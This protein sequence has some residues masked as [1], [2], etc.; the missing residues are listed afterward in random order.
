MVLQTAGTNIRH[1]QT[2]T[3]N[4]MPM[5]D[6]ASDKILGCEPGTIIW[7]HERA[8]QI[9]YHTNVSTQNNTFKWWMLLLCLASLAIDNILLAKTSIIAILALELG[10]ELLC[11]HYALRKEVKG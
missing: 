11:W 10:E 4:I 8:H 5:Y 1:R 3:K 9:L 6:P 7:Q 2:K